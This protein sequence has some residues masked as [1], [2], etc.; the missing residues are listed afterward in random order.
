MY[1]SNSED[2]ENKMAKGAMSR[3]RFKTIKKCIHFGSI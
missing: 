2:T 1:W 3:D